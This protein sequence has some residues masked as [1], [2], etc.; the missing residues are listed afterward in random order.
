[1]NVWNNYGAIDDQLQY[2]IK[3]EINVNGKELMGMGRNG[4]AIILSCPAN[5]ERPTWKVTATFWRDTHCSVHTATG[6]LPSLSPPNTYTPTS[7]ESSG[8]VLGKL[9]F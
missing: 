4:N 5:I 1:M 8:P 6:P 3:F 2:G 9:L 7:S